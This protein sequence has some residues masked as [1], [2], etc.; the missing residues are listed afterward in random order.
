MPK[1][2]IEID[3][4]V[5]FMTHVKGMIKQN[6]ASQVETQIG[7]HLNAINHEIKSIKEEQLSRN[8][9]IDDIHEM[10]LG[11][12]KKNEMGLKKEHDEMYRAFIITRGM[13]YFFGFTSV[14]NLIG[15]VVLVRDFII[16]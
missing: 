15:F 6:T 9:K 7:M 13:L 12:M 10:L 8:N 11:S 1:P 16:K 4:L 5:E 14:L 3:R 2:K